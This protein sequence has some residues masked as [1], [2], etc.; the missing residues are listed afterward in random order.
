MPFTVRALQTE[1]SVIGIYKGMPT[2][3]ETISYLNERGFHPQRPLPG[4]PRQLAPSG[5]V[6]TA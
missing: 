1:A 6:P 3:M 2:Y 5:R 4:G